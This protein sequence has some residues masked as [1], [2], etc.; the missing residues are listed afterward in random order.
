MLLMLQ[1]NRGL[2]SLVCQKKGNIFFTWVYICF[3]LHSSSLCGNSIR[4]TLCFLPFQFYTITALLSTKLMS[5]LVTVTVKKHGETHYAASFPKGL[6][7]NHCIHHILTEHIW[8]GLLCTY[9]SKSLASSIF[10]RH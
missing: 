4:K 1:N 10:T 8:H 6:S 7:F 2:Y 3:N 9:L 5:S